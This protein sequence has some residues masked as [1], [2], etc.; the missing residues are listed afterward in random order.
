MSGIHDEVV[1]DGK[2]WE[3]LANGKLMKNLNHQK[4]GLSAVKTTGCPEKSPVLRI[5]VVF[6]TLS[7]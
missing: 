3:D 6:W 1:E 5:E 2:G 7:S 4:M